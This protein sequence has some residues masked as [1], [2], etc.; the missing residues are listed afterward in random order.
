MENLKKLCVVS[1]SRIKAMRE[2][3]ECL[4]FIGLL[5]ENLFVLDKEFLIHQYFVFDDLFVWCRSY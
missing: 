1:L 5:S 2:Y 4:K 3:D